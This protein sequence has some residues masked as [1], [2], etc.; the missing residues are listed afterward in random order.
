MEASA[1]ITAGVFA[2]FLQC[3]TKAYLAHC[4]EPA[5]FK[6]EELR[7]RLSA[8]YKSSV[9]APSQN[10]AISFSCLTDPIPDHLDKVLVDSE[11]ASYNTG[12]PV[13]ARA[14]RRA[15][16]ASN[17]AKRVYIPVLYSPWEENKSADL[18]IC[19]GA[20]AIAQ[21]MGT[22]VPHKGKLVYGQCRQS[23]TVSVRPH[24][25][26]TAS[27]LAE[28]R[29]IC[30]STEPPPLILNQHCAT[31]DFRAACRAR[32]IDQDNLS[33]LGGMTAKERRRCQEKGIS[34]VTQLSYGYRPRRRRRVSKI[35][36]PSKNDSRLKALAI[37]K[38]Q[39]H[40]VGSPS[41][42]LGGTSVFMDV[43]GLADRDFY[44]LVGI[45]YEAHGQQVVNRSEFAGGIVV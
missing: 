11:T 17:G 23:R 35:V 30:L 13:N 31:C 34:T 10:A 37:K 43:E 26:K 22:Q 44:Y 9:V 6:F 18:L 21:A 27:L 15:K 33:L 36:T 2:A 24:I 1:T 45:R 3:R 40:V 16:R 19:F 25:A 7:R 38:R 28:I 5:D 4:Q 8:A 39:I 12:S 29:S 20:L 32:A 42:S 14:N 41:L